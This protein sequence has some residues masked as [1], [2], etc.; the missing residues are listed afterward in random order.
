MVGSVGVRRVRQGVQVPP[1]HVASQALRVSTDRGT[2][3]LP[4]VSLPDQVEVQ[5][6]QPHPLQAPSV[7]RPELAN[8]ETDLK[9]M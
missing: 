2:V 5:P 6:A 8:G 1:Q 3:L 9:K 7:R 4:V